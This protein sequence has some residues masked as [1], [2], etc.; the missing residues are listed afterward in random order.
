MIK[1]HLGCG[2]NRIDGFVNIDIQS[3]PNVDLV[4]DVTNLP[5]SAESVDEIYS[6]AVI[7]H[8]G[9]HKWVSVLDYWVSLLKPGGVLRLST[10][11]FES[12]C[13]EYLENKDIKKLLGLI[14]GGQKDY[15]DQHGMVFDFKIFKQELEGLGMEKVRRYDWEEFT[16]FQSN[17]NYDDYSRSYLPHM[18]FQNGRLMMLNVVCQKSEV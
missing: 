7:E 18:D 8:F 16:P 9:R 14:V 15:T 6:C 17:S 4:A 10:A 2:K 1:L 12:C 3:A 5:Y 11:D 13:I